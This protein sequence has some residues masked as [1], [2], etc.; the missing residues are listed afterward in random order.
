[1]I[2]P[3]SYSQIDQDLHVLR[4]FCNEKNLFFLDIGANDGKTLSNSYLLEKEY[5]WNGICA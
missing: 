5:N 2:K 4:F 3:L 1:M